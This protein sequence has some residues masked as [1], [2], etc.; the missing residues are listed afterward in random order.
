MLATKQNKKSASSRV[1][2]KVRICYNENKNLENGDVQ[3][4]VRL[5]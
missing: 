2:C 5:G 4:K 1:Q 3:D